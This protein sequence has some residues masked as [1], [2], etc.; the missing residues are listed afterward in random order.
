[1]DVMVDVMAE[2]EEVMAGDE[3]EDVAAEVED[4]ED[5]PVGEVEDDVAA[6]AYT[7]PNSS[8]SC[9]KT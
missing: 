4:E 3:V 9:S 1:M 8:S 6:G 5:M 7:S 2:D